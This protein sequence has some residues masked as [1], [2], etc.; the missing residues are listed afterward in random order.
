MIPVESK[1]AIVGSLILVLH[2]KLIWKSYSWYIHEGIVIG[3][4]SSCEIDGVSGGIY[5]TFFNSCICILLD[6]GSIGSCNMIVTSRLDKCRKW[7]CKSWVGIWKIRIVRNAGSWRI[8]R[9]EIVNL[10]S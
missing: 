9:I 5:H 10:G 3:K 4:F 2:P 6:V 1:R 7:I 8:P